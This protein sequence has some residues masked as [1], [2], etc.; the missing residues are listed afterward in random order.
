MRNKK[1][2]RERW[3]LSAAAILICLLAAAG[4]ALAY[5]IHWKLLKNVF[6]VGYNDITIVEQY[7]P[8][9]ELKE[10]VNSYAKRIQIKNTGKISCYVRMLMK[11]SDSEIE[12]ISELSPDGREYYHAE[13]YADYLPEHWRYIS[14]AEDELLGGYYYY[15]EEL[16]ANKLSKPLVEKVKTT[17]GKA[18]DVAAYEIYVYSESVQVLDKNGEAF[19]GNEPYLDAWR[20]FLSQSGT[21]EHGEK[22]V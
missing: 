3:R 13:N 12:K 5:F 16:A 2:I 7:D 20:E 8:P 15:T 10:G 22:G 21:T 6:S 4:A 19:T 18:E 11:F 17:F 14:E 1:T 9:K